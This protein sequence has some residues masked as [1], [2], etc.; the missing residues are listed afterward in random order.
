MLPFDCQDK[1]LLEGFLVKKIRTIA[2]VLA[3]KND[4]K[5]AP[6]HI[7]RIFCLIFTFISISPLFYTKTY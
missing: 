6:L 5:L 7:V 3:A 2:G 1:A 4:N